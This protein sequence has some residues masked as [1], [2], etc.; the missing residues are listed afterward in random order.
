MEH[1]RDTWQYLRDRKLGV[2]LAL[3]VMLFDQLTKG[4]ALGVLG[5]GGQTVIDGFLRYSLAMNRGVSFSF[6]ASIP[7]EWLP[8]ALAAFALIASGFFTHMM[9]KG[10]TLYQAGLGLIVGGAI[11]NM[12][13]RLNYGGVIDFIS[14]YHGDWYFPTFNVADIAI[15][16][17]VAFVLLDTVKHIVKK[18]SAL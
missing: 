17:G 16:I 1:V 8:L 5:E 4:W 6:F 9:G 14:V 3:L 12:I 7:H 10:S 15:N 13:D 18:E 2:R 11:G